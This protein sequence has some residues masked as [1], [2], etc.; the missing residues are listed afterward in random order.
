MM[1]ETKKSRAWRVAAT[2]PALLVV[3]VAGLFLPFDGA[4]FLSFWAC[5]V[6]VASLLPV[7]L[8]V[9]LYMLRGW[10]R[11]RFPLRRADILAA[12]ILSSL[13]ILLAC[14]A[15]VLLW[16]VVESL[17]HISFM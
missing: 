13:D 3:A 14:A 5:V 12:T 10:R 6:L 8:G 1:T 11:G 15:V 16:F 9:L 2:P 17:R 4:V 7:G